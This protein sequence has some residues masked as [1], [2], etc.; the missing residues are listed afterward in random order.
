M[1]Q[2][3][4]ASFFDYLNAERVNSIGGLF[5]K[6]NDLLVPQLSFAL[7]DVAQFLKI[8][9]RSEGAFRPGVDEACD[10]H[11]TEGTAIGQTQAVVFAN[12]KGKHDYNP[13]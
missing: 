7:E 11:M 10:V 3:R 9:C 2:N 5:P 1:R 6:R 12:R 8:R 13:K 4:T